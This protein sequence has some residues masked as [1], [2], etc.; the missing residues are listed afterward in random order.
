MLA[1]H[2]QVFSRSLFFPRSKKDDWN[3]FTFF[4]ESKTKKGI[5]FY[6]CWLSVWIRSQTHVTE[7]K[8]SANCY[9]VTSMFFLFRNYLPFCLISNKGRLQSDQIRQ[10]QLNAFLKLRIS[11]RERVKIIWP[12]TLIYLNTLSLNLKI[13]LLLP[14][15][16][17]SL[18]KLVKA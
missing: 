8:T 12:L 9:D 4:L 7:P 15:N 5:F 1:R 13:I 14:L 18:F 6:Q 2:L 11:L 3:S 10:V 16:H 17:T